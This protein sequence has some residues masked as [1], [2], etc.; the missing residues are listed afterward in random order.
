MSLSANL[1]TIL[2]LLIAGFVGAAFGTIVRMVINY[3]EEIEELYS[4][5]ENCE[6][7]I[8]ETE[9]HELKKMISKIYQ[10]V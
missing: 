6:E 2:K 8:S 5:L 9:N 4:R 1:K 10:H 3:D 7:K